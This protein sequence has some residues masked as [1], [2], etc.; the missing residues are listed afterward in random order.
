M[1]HIKRQHY[2]PKCYLSAFEDDATGKIW[3]MQI[4]P[5]YPGGPRLVSAKQ[6]CYEDNFYEFD[7]CNDTD[8]PVNQLERAWRTIENQWRSLVNIVDSKPATLSND[9]VSALIFSAISFKL[10]NPSTRGRFQGPEAQEIAERNIQEGMRN[11]KGF[12]P[13]QLTQ[14]ETHLRNNI[15][16]KGRTGK[17]LHN[18]ILLSIAEN[19]NPSLSRKICDWLSTHEVKILQTTEDKPFITTD[20]PGL[21]LDSK[22]GVHNLKFFGMEN[23]LDFGGFLLPLSPKQC[24][25]VTPKGTNVHNASSRAVTYFELDTSHLAEINFH[26]IRLSRDYIFCND[27]LMLEGCIAAYLHTDLQKKKVG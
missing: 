7:S 11:F 15:I 8:V 21:F 16:M 19:G 14:I 9:S 23:H 25:F 22:G 4:N 20:N 24:L 5:K 13:N 17:N 26:S 1:N 6:V 3:A 27:K 10:R 18:G 12:P 2:L